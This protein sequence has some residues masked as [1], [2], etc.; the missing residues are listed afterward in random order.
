MSTRP[1]IY[2]RPG[3][4]DMEYEGARQCPS[5]SRIANGKDWS[6]TRTSVPGRGDYADRTLD[7]LSC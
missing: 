2:A 4:Y 1:D 3:V 5:G 7:T 6:V